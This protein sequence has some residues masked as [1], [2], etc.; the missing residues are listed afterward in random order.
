ME[1]SARQGTSEN[2]FERSEGMQKPSELPSGVV[3]DSHPFSDRIS[4]PCVDREM[5]PRTKKHVLQIS[6]SHA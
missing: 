6:F 2:S 1:F 3:L 4:N 5:R